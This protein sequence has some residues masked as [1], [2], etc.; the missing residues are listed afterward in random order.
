[1]ECKKHIFAVHMWEVTVVEIFGI[2]K[3]AAMVMVSPYSLKI[4]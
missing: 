1:M 4:L 3:H 2:K